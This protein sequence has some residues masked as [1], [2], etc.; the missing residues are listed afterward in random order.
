MSEK[1]VYEY[2]IK[3]EDF[4][5]T[6]KD[7]V[8]HFVSETDHVAEIK[9]SIFGEEAIKEFEEKLNEHNDKVKKVIVEIATEE[10]NNGTKEVV[11]TYKEDGAK[12]ENYIKKDGDDV[13]T[14]TKYEFANK[15]PQVED[16]SKEIK[17]V[18]S[19]LK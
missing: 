8:D 17:E 3:K 2:E 13:T 4:V 6:T 16:I 9:K 10:L 19:S 15:G 5:K 14:I 12:R 7:G 11:V 18:L 1:K